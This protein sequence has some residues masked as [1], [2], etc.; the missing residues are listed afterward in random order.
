VIL[1]EPF[2]GLDP[3]MRDEFVQGVLELAGEGGWSAVISS[4]DL[5]EI[6][7]LIDQVGYLRDGRLAFTESIVS[8]QSRFRQFDIAAVSGA[9]VGVAPADAGPVG[10]TL[11]PPQPLPIGWLNVT[12]SDRALRFVH[13][14]Y[15]PEVTEQEM[16]ARF[17]GA[18]IQVTPLSLRETFIALA[19][20]ERDDV[21]TA[22][23]RD[24]G[25][26]RDEGKLVLS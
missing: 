7:R 15:A 13:A 25:V 16:R 17:P 14:R 24:K 6:E 8:L 23:R 11:L 9:P 12:T 22:G 3:L 2:S 21:R 18:Q 1:D 26:R 4:H 19:R 10:A 20:Q 5:E